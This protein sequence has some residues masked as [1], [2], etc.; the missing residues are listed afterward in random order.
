MRRYQLKNLKLI[1]LCMLFVIGCDDTD[2][3]TSTTDVFDSIS[4]NGMIEGSFQYTGVI[5]YQ[6]DDCTGNPITEMCNYTGYEEI[7][8]FSQ[9]Q[10]ESVGGTMEPLIDIFTNNDPTCAPFLIFGS[11]G[12]FIDEDCE[13]IQYT[14]DSTTYAIQIDDSYCDGG[15]FENINTESACD[16]VNG[17]W[18]SEIINGMFNLSDG[19]ITLSQSQEGDCNDG[20]YATQEECEAANEDWNESECFEFTLTY[21]PDHDGTCTGED[22]CD[23][24]SDG[25]ESDDDCEDGEECLDGECNLFVCQSSDLDCD[26]NQEC[27]DGVCIDLIECDSDEDC[28]VYQECVGVCIDSYICTNNA[29][30]YSD[31]II[32]LLAGTASAADC[33]IAM[34]GLLEWCEAGCEYAD[35]IADEDQICTEDFLGYSDEDISLECA[36][37]HP[38]N[39]GF[40]LTGTF[41]ATSFTMYSTEDCS[42]DGMT[43]MCLDGVSTNEAACTEAGHTWMSYSDMIGDLSVTFNSDGTFYDSYYPDYIMTYTCSSADFCTDS[44][45]TIFSVNSD[46][47]ITTQSGYAA[48]CGDYDDE[49]EYDWYTNQADCEANGSAEGAAD[50]VW[51]DASC[52]TIIWTESN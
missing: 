32:G 9:E 10:C 43:G 12:S 16:S 7:D 44:D 18:N 31:Y 47:S 30:I 41:T 36:V 19:S 34:S 48:Y 20:Q 46:G 24:G 28:E 38:D 26:T 2:D 33:E 45:G 27:V 23:D 4:E 37:L 21:A 8:E 15:D 50:G 11:D 35:D 29:Q 40:F 52:S 49:V 17:Y 1:L 13:S 3:P 6:N 5:I 51:Y 42:G 39:S 22:L 14:L 25:C